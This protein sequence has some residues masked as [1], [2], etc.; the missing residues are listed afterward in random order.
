MA[1]KGFWNELI[2]FSQVHSIWLKTLIMIN[3]GQ[4]VTAVLDASAERG[5]C[6]RRE[7]MLVC[8]PRNSK[9]SSASLARGIRYICFS[10]RAA[11]R[12][13][14]SARGKHKASRILVRYKPDRAQS[15]V[16][17][18]ENSCQELWARRCFT[19][20]RTTQ[21]WLHF[22]RAICDIHLVRPPLWPHHFWRF[23]NPF[24]FNVPLIS[25]QNIV[26]INAR[27]INAQLTAGE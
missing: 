11:A 23:T 6:L 1:S 25:A 24:W 10:S 17:L 3:N 22:A 15:A 16:R 18:S 19:V 21:A 2:L 9:D 8:N 27:L 13:C 14:H 7:I 4:V 26:K 5:K 12:W 20:A